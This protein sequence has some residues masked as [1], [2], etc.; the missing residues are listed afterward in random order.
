VAGELYYPDIAG[1]NVKLITTKILG[2]II[3]EQTKSLII[4]AP[5][6]AEILNQLKLEVTHG[7]VAVL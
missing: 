5:N 1:F 7:L 6:P 4:S 2:I 3:N